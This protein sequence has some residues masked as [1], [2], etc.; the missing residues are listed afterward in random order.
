MLAFVS[1]VRTP[2]LLFFLVM[3]CGAAHA[4]VQEKKLMD[5][6]NMSKDEI[7]TMK[8]DVRKSSFGSNGVSTK[9]ATTKD[10]GGSREFN[11]RSFLSK[12]VCH[13]N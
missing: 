4:Q 8:Y 6:L 9:S 11:T 10:F 2:A 5:R 12:C 3:L 7:L 1:A 13:G